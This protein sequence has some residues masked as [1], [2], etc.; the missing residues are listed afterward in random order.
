MFQT[1]SF[2]V[3][4]MELGNGGVESVGHVGGMQ[5]DHSVV[6][7]YAPLKIVAEIVGFALILLLEYLGGRSRCPHKC[8]EVHTSQ[9]KVARFL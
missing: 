8:D 5:M 7:G 3:A 4:K 6:V 1:L 2:V 9:S